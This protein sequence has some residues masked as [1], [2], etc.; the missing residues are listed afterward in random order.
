LKRYLGTDPYD[1]TVTYLLSTREGL[2]NIIYYLQ[3][4][5]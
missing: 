2:G 5:A 1:D 4:F 3:R